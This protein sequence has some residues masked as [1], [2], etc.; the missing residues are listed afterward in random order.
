MSDKNRIFELAE[1]SR[2]KNIFVYTDFLNEQAQHEL[3]KNYPQSFVAFWGGAE[4]AERKIA[5]FGNADDIGY[6]ENFPLCIVKI[7]LLGGKF[8]TE[9]RHRDVLG[10]LM[11]QGIVREKVGDIFIGDNRCFAVLHQSVAP[12]VSQNL[13]TVGKNSVSVQTVDKI[14]EKVASTREERKFSVQS[15]RLDSIVSKVFGV[16]R[17]KS[18]ELIETE[19]VSI[20][21]VLCQKTARTLK[22]G[23]K[24]SVR[25]FGKFEFVGE[26]GTSRKGKTY[27][28][29]EMFL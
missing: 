15:N 16:S 25:G 4:F 18:C 26:C 6:E 29:I 20:D 11:S 8:A 7:E 14:D 28:D 19:K 23:E 1:R 21:G 22:H 12:F 3:K 24:V 10:A 27:F 17:E 5:R 13:T 2:L 9:V